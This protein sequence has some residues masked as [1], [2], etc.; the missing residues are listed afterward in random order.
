MRKARPA[1]GPY[2]FEEKPETCDVSASRGHEFRWRTCP[3]FSRDR[4]ASRIHA[5]VL[6][7]TVPP[8]TPVSGAKM[9]KLHPHHFQTSTG[10]NEPSGFVLHFFCFLL[11][12]GYVFE[13]LNRSQKTISIGP[14]SSFEVQKFWY[15]KCCRA[16]GVQLAR[17]AHFL[18]LLRTLRN[19]RLALALV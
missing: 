7:M 5:R 15:R 3:S 13:Y 18:M 9:Q 6:A 4:R 19:R 2:R 17:L 16:R 11:A 8:L 14:N 1:S 12:F 10:P